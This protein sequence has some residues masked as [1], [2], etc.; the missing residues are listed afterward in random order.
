MVLDA[1]IHK[2]KQIIT[3]IKA[4]FEEAV[5]RGEAFYIKK[6]ILQ[7]LRL[8]MNELDQLEIAIKAKDL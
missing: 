1:R 8:A 5:N 6:E 2:L 4:E 7:R 3:A